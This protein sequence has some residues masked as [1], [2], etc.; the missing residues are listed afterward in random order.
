MGLRIEYLDTLHLGQTAIALRLRRIEKSERQVQETARCRNP[1]EIG[2]KPS[3]R[4][5]RA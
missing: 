3:G 1:V 4:Q 2:N 5:V